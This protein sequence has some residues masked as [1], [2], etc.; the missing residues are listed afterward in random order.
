MLEALPGFLAACDEAVSKEAWKVFTKQ[1][2]KIHL[3]VKIGDVKAGKKGVTI[4]WTD[5]RARRRC[6]RPTG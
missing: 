2:L 1:G 4:A 6:S 5:A 3:G